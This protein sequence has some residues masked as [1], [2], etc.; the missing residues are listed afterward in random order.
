MAKYHTVHNS[1]LIRF[2]IIVV[3]VEHIAEKISNMHIMFLLIFLHDTVGVMMFIT[4][5]AKMPIQHDAIRLK[6]AF[7]AMIVS[8]Y[9]VFSSVS[10]T[11]VI[12]MAQS[13]A[14]LQMPLR[15]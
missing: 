3:T 4:A 8:F 5:P 12:L 11:R 15:E 7:A 2:T 14:K 6:I 13:S 9:S 1:K 10:T